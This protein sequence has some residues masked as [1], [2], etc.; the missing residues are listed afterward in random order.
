MFE[1]LSLIHIFNADFADDVENNI[2]TAYKTL[3]L[4]YDVEFDS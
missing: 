3:W 1:Y 2:L 4:A